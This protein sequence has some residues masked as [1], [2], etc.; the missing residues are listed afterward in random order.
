MILYCCVRRHNPKVREIEPSV[1][2]IVWY[3]DELWEKTRKTV[4]A[5]QCLCC[6]VCRAPYVIDTIEQEHKQFVVLM[7]MLGL[8]M[9]NVDIGMCDAAKSKASDGET[10][11]WLL[12]CDSD[13]ASDDAGVAKLLSGSHR[14][15]HPRQLPISH[16]GRVEGTNTT[17]KS[18]LA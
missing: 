18:A 4:S 10:N 16:L 5:W 13:L 9:R 6:R 17:M 15:H 3:M 14:S 12:L 1:R 2:A 7:N 11:K 8:G